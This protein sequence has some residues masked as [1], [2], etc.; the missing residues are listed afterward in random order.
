MHEQV[1]FCLFLT[2]VYCFSV[3]ASQLVGK[4]LRTRRIW[5]CHRKTKIFYC[6]IFI[7]LLFNAC[8]WKELFLRCGCGSSDENFLYLNE[9]S[10]KFAGIGT[11][12]CLDIL[13]SFLG[14]RIFADMC[15]INK[16]KVLNN[17]SRCSLPCI[18][19]FL[20][21]FYLQLGSKFLVRWCTFTNALDEYIIFIE[22]YFKELE[23][24]ILLVRDMEVAGVRPLAAEAAM[25]V[26]LGM[27]IGNAE[28]SF[29]ISSDVI[30]TVIRI[31]FIWILFLG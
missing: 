5:S 18:L 20:R 27:S 21:K 7:H 24:P 9:I 12:K 22:W 29:Q 30:G 28:F 23:R 19:C 4:W 17:F 8:A 2:S 6:Q 31:L 1:K 16:V 10:F 13:L 15:P 3:W 26:L 11:V 25:N 14:L